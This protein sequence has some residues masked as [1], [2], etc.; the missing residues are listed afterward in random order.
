MMIET[1]MADRGFYAIFLQS[2]RL[3]RGFIEISEKYFEKLM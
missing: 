2:E 3:R 1:V